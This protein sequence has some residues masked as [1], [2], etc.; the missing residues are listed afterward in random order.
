MLRMASAVV[1]VSEALRAAVA[2]VAPHSRLSVIGN[3]VNATQFENLKRGRTS[4]FTVLQVGKFDWNKGQD[5]LLRALKQ[6]T[7]RNIACQAVLVG[8][9]GP[10]LEQTKSLIA[11]LGLESSVTLHVDVPHAEIPRFMAIADVLVLPSRAESFGLVLIEAGAAGVPVIAT[12][13]GGIPELV[14]HERTGILI[15]PESVDLLREAI[16]RLMRDERL[17]AQI[18]AEM[19]SHVLAYCTW[20]SA[21][22]NYEALIRNLASE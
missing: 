13:V 9:S 1:V 21:A 3:G 18:S 4:V 2:E 10:D 19:R 15:P 14:K 6:M 11:E 8:G 12:A 17:C 16:E 22:R 5:L 20:A 7:D